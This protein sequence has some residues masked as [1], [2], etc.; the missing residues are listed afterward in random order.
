MV[1]A[2]A[3]NDHLRLATV[4]EPLDVEALVTQ[5]TVERFVRPVPPRLAWIDQ[6]GIDA[7]L[8]QPPQDHGANPPGSSVELR[9]L[10]PN[11][12]PHERSPRRPTSG[13]DS[14]VRVARGDRQKLP[15]A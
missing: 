4:A 15:I 14:D 10:T 13:D 1:P 11:V 2:P 3:L 5:L 7:V 8:K 9:A 6:S 12:R